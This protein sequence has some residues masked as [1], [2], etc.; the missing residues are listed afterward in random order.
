MEK[1]TKRIKV[2]YF[3]EW[4]YGMS[5][6]DL[7][8]DLDKIEKLGATHVDIEAYT[9]YD[10]AYVGI[11]PILQRTETDEEAIKRVSDE[12]SRMEML[13]KRELE[14][15]KKLKEKYPQE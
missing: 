10:C 1:L 13:K 12:E 5:I 6:Y 3:L 7:R 4:E 8:K 2:D 9:S 14:Q 11:E 15:L